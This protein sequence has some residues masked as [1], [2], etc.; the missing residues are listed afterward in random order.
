MANRKT[1][2]VN[3][4]PQNGKNVLKKRLIWLAA[5]VLAYTVIGFFVAPAVIKSQLLERLPVLTKRQAAVRQVLCNPYSL[6]LTIRGLALTE[7]NNEPFAGFEELYV[8]FELSSIFHGAWVFSE[9]SIKQPFAQATRLADGKFNFDNLILPADT[10]APPPAKKPLPSVIVD[11]LT[12]EGA[13]LSVS[14]LTRTSPFQTKIAPI[15]I[16]LTDFTTRPN[17]DDPYS[18]VATSESGESFAWA[19]NVTVEP[20][21][22]SGHFKIG[23]L[24]LKKYAPYL[25]D[26][27]KAE[28]QDG[29]LDVAADYKLAIGASGLDLTVSKGTVQLTDLQV[30]SHSPD[31]TVLSVPSLSVDLTEASL[32]KKTIQIASIKSSGG[33]MLARQ[34]ADGTI[35]LLQ[36]IKPLPPVEKT[37][38]TPAAPWVANV[39]ELTLDNYTVQFEDKKPAKATKLKLD[40]IA[41][42]CKGF[43]TASNTVITPTL[44]LRLNEAG[45]MSVRG[46]AK[47]LPLTA[48]LV[49]DLANVDMRPFQPYVQEQ[50][51]LAITG[52]QLSVHGYARYAVDA[53]APLISFT[54]DVA[55][56]NFATTDLVQFKDF[57][58]FTNLNVKGID[59]ALQP[60]KLD[61]KEVNVNG[62]NTTVA[63]DTNKQP[64]LLS[65]LPKKPADTNAPPAAALAFPINLGL[66]NLD[67]ASFHLADASV[68]PNCL[69][70]IQDFGGTILGLS[71]ASN[72]TATV[73]LKGKVDAASPF[74][75]SGKINPLS[76][77][78]MADVTISMKNMDLTPFTPYME[79]F[80]GYPLNKGKL[81]LELHYDIA[82]RKLKAENK[83]AINLLTLGGRNNNT[84][85]THLPVKL[86]IALLKDRNGKIDLDVP[87]SGNFDDPKFKV[88]PIVLQV[89]MNLLAK[90]AT[91]PF[92]LLG[93]MFGGGDELSY[94]D[95]PPGQFEIPQTE[96]NKLDKL[97]KALFE[98]PALSLEI[99]GAADRAADG[100]MVARAK[101]DDQILSLRTQELIASGK[102]TEAVHVE[103]KD[104]TRLLEKLYLKSIGTNQ[105]IAAPVTNAAVVATNVPP[106]VETP[107][108]NSAPRGN[109]FTRSIAKIES[110]LPGGKEKQ[111]L[112]K[113]PSDEAQPAVAPVPVTV[114]APTAK[115]QITV[116]E[117]VAALTAGLPVT[118]NDLRELMQR[119]AHSV[120]AWLLNSGK[121]TADRLFILTPKPTAKPEMRV[122]LTLE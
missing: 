41:L 108:T 83:V 97:S 109:W 24:T 106:P 36:L 43:S 99:V 22:S 70:D 56:T 3:K 116:E 88:G 49:V 111:A 19:G 73:D 68:E 80:G 122:N 94:V 113:K 63:V 42:D 85:A 62:F 61:I 6:S 65:I 26:F 101:L 84:N 82:Q 98:R 44:S 34:N 114:A 112:T 119:R 79:K 77:D 16:H 115:G 96:T 54:G 71:S 95:F 38:N 121:V 105:P 14:D 33:S 10:N 59:F 75:V 58:K 57:V 48:D 21:Q 29:K 90:A 18:F 60:N 91:S 39:D 55:V 66:L 45:T 7:T 23:Q 86:A 67:N 89:V 102:V 118:D 76:K 120:Q 9:I 5:I 12:I 35:N 110:W 32:A 64:N 2:T 13:A 17:T 50:A 1:Y 87:L 103:P 92:S 47:I 100:A 107:T 28:V 40:Q 15:N 46:T 52:G 4:A 20:L 69:F 93:A 72:S 117:M 11:V 53:K 74:S 81:V 30:K 31:E 27:T 25:S 8:N 51:K 37:T 78:I 104:Y